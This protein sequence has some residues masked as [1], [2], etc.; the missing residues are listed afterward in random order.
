MLVGTTKH[1]HCIIFQFL[2]EVQSQKQ[3]EGLLFWRCEGKHVVDRHYE[4]RD[5]EGAPEAND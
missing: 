3:V 4:E 2:F 5:H 1:T